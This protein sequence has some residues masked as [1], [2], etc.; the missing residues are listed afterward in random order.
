[1][2][3]IDLDSNRDSGDLWAIT[4][5]FNP[6]GY[7]RRLANYQVFRQRLSIPLIAVELAYGPNFELGENDADILIQVRGGDVMWQKE[8]LLNVALR[9]LPDDC[10][11]VVWVDC[12]IIFGPD[13]W[14]EILS[15]LLDRYM[16]L[17]P[18]GR[19]HHLP[20]DWTPRQVNASAAE[21]SRASVGYGIA[22]GM[23]ASALTGEVP[24]SGSYVYSRGLAWAA[25]RELLDRHGLYDACIIGG[26]DKAM[27]AAIYGCY[28]PAMH[29]LGMNDRQRARYLAWAEPFHAMIGLAAGWMRGDIYHL[30][31]GDTRDRWTAYRHTIL[32][33]FGFDPFEDIVI[34]ASGCW[35]W[36]T[37]KP[38]MH[39]GVRDYF[40][41]RKE[42]G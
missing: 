27:T 29:F 12:D 11:K 3:T 14:S 25:R 41:S 18:F 37:D 16:I 35:R 38:H 31:H 5:Y 8:R 24:R 34:A 15:C 22:S 39:A 2:S 40:A 33:R 17:Q 4:S 42:D 6:I 7:R 23:S 20:R 36:N 32:T 13:N 26:G 19:V 9:A 21:F 28:D 30:W 1:M 10:K